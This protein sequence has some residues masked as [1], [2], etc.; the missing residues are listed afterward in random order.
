MRQSYPGRPA[1]QRLAFLPDSC[2]SLRRVGAA[3]LLTLGLATATKAQQRLTQNFFQPDAA[4][5]A[6]AA[7]PLAATLP[8]ARAQALTLDAPSLRAALATA[9]PETRAG[10]APLVLALPRPDGSS[11]RFAL[12]EA[13]IMEAPLAARYPQIR[14]YAGVGLDDATATVRVDLTPQGFHAQVL[15]GTGPGFLI[16]PVSPADTRHYL[17][18]NEKDV[19]AAASQAAQCRTVVTP[20]QEQASAARV[21][22]WRG[23]G[24]PGPAARLSGAQLRSYRLTLSSTPEFSASCGNTTAD[25]LAVLVTF[26]NQMNGIFER[27]LAVR[28][29]LVADNDKLIFLSGTGPQAP[30]PYTSNVPQQNQLN[31]DQL[32]GNANY[33]LGLVLVH[34]GGGGALVS[35]LGASG[36]KAI[37]I[38]GHPMPSDYQ[39][40]RYAA[41]E[42]G[43]ILGATHTFNAVDINNRNGPTAWEP[44]AG[45]T[46]MS[47]CGTYGPDNNVQRQTETFF[48]TGSYEQVMATTSTCNCGTLTATGN[49]P[50]VVT[51]PAGG[52]TLPLNTPFRLTAT[53]TDADNDPLTYS[54]EELDTG[55]AGNLTIPQVAG[56]TP[57]LFRTRPPVASPTR[58]FPRLADLANPAPATAPATGERLPTVA[59]TL[60]FRCTARDLHPGP[61]GVVGGVDYSALVSLSVS[62]AAG[63]FVVTAPTAAGT[64]WAGG[65]TQTVTW[66]VANTNVAPVSCAL[67]NLRLSLD[68]GLS[69]PLELASNVPNSGTASIVV[70][71]A[72][73][74]TA[75]VI[76]EAADNY[77]FDISNADFA[78]T[79]GPG[80]VISSFTPARGPAGTV[81]TLTGLNFTGATAV[82]IN[83]TAASFNVISATSLTAT[84]AAGST[85]GLITVT[86]PAG[87]GTSATPFLVGSPPTITSFTP[88]SGPLFTD[89]TVTGTNFL[90]TTQVQV[91]GRDAKFY[92]VSATQLTLTVPEYTGAGPL[93]VTTPFGT[94]TSTGVFTVSPRPFINSFA[95]TQGPE[96]TTVVL[97]G[98][99]FAGATQVR[100]GGISAPGFTVNSA[101]QITATV[102][103]G[104]LTGPISVATSAGLGVSGNSFTVVPPPL[105]TAISP[106]SGVVGMSV[107]LTGT[108]LDQ[109]TTLTL[110]GVAV[111]GFIL[112]N[113]T[114]ITFVV[115]AGATTGAVLGTA[116]GGGGGSSVRFTVLT[117]APS[118]VIGG[119]V[120]AQ[121]IT[122][123]TIGL[124]GTGFTGATLVSFSG[125]GANTVSSG[126]AVNAAGT[127]LSGLVVPNG[128]I[129]GTLTVTTSAGTSAASIQ[130]FTVCALPTAQAQNAQ[131]ALNAAGTAT[132]LPTAVN[133]GSSANCGVAAAATLSVAPNTF[134]T[135]DLGPPV[136]ASALR[137]NGSGQYVAIGGSSAMPI[138]NS[139]YTIEA[140]VKPATMGGNSIIGWGYFGFSNA[141]NALRLSPTGLVNYW[142]GN[143]LEVPTPSL[144]G[145]WHHV[146]ATFDG[147]TR[148]LYLDGAAVGSDQPGGGHD[149]FNA[150]NLRI[151]STNSG[152]FFNGSIDEVRVWNV[153]RT[154]AQLNGA[155]GAHLLRN[156]A[157]LVAYYRFGEGSGLATADANGV[158]ANAG[159]LTGGAAWTTDAPTIVNGV[160]VV[161][162]VTDASG[163]P[164]TASAVVLVNPAGPPLPVELV[165]FTAQAAGPAVRL[166][167]ATASEKN[168]ALFE[169]ERS[170][171]GQ[172]FEK[173]GQVAA[174]GTKISPTNYTYLDNSLI[175][176]ATHSLY[177][178][179]RQVDRD[180]TFT[181]SPVRTVT[182]S[183]QPGN[184]GGLT[185]VPNPAP[186]HATTLA[187]AEVRAAVDVFDTLGRRVLTATADADGT[188]A[189]VLP[190][191]LPAGVYVVRSGP[192]A[193]RLVVE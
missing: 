179:L 110:N 26:T 107:T 54:W 155:K 33:D 113:A 65:T 59:R 20:A 41:H 72:P 193:V 42:V 25:V 182:F 24:G 101:T 80:P 79:P 91:S 21:A 13:P 67:V 128:A 84:V 47:Y 103:P 32:I 181:Y 116:N 89:V 176:S 180:G 30:F 44:G 105:L 134:T 93:T 126:F 125:S 88:T 28:L 61:L 131:V 160:P 172:K 71:N 183:G 56:E 78:I 106:T 140:W 31:V 156:P 129:T 161:L 53:A 136:V 62:A 15:S 99:L 115:P 152:E 38:A 60:K 83:G 90:N 82:A 149:V 27:D 119:I 8:L 191:G 104:A 2:P 130:V 95:P 177:Y 169:V 69:Y 162:T 5:R 45:V 68:G 118:V 74:A 173:V 29:V 43:H 122:G 48:H 175:H 70:P 87:T 138:H 146:A 154:A 46:L 135:A 58:Y 51:A 157:G 55:P 108:T 188:A 18:Y 117:P 143:D 75:R 98:Y 145:A 14:T 102:P 186:D 76:V 109:V 97:S 3:L 167:W 150:S 148:T 147:T 132:L 63:P 158:A 52:K 40:V 151:G 6:A 57:P 192:R 77:F 144:V 4:A 187:G 159:T 9:P 81:V 96:G 133:S 171:D 37:N 36:F 34:N 168:S 94:V 190:A 165:S 137:L 164:A 121:G 64:S 73:T 12:R 185:L 112:V 11:A 19:P 174:Q 100:F 123:A 114:T 111:P 170:A 127:E 35:G 85:S 86:T 142:W 178:R 141:V 50:P 39:L 153:A 189:F 124:T 22:A 17:A 49:T 92:V 120:P 23:A 10:A 184:G 16:A 1:T 139:P 66:D 7:S 163:H 166:A